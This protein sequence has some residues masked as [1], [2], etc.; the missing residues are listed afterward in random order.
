MIFLK[1]KGK[2]KILLD[3]YVH[4]LC[5]K[6]LKSDK[7]NKNWDSIMSISGSVWLQKSY[8]SNGFLSMEVDKGALPFWVGLVKLFSSIGLVAESNDILVPCLSK[9]FT[10]LLIAA[11]FCKVSVNKCWIWFKISS[12]PLLGRIPKL[13]WFTSGAKIVYTK[14]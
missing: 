11:W 14:S 6:K 13:V 10:I 5:A 8:S 2:S 3:M 7:E 12:S 1:V 9:A 4:L